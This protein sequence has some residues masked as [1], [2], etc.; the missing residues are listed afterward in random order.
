MP[1]DK[2]VNG[3]DRFFFF[4]F[5]FADDGVADVDGVFRRRM[6]FSSSS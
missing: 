4:F 2:A 1:H 3:K 5:F 6:P